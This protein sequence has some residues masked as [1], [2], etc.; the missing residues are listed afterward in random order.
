MKTKSEK[1]DWI[2]AGFFILMWLVLIIFG[3]I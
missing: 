3:V 2:L 1:G